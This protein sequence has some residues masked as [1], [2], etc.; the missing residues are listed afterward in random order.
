MYKSLL[1]FKHLKLI[2]LT[3]LIG[4][5]FSCSSSDSSD[6]FVEEISVTFS[7]SNT[8]VILGDSTILSWA[9]ETGASCVAGDG[10]TG[11]KQVSGNQTIYINNFGDNIFSLTCSNNS[12]AKKVSIVVKGTSPFEDE[13]ANIFGTTKYREV[14]NENTV[15]FPSFQFLIPIKLNADNIQDFIAHYWCDINQ[16]LW[17]TDH[18]QSTPDLIVAYLSHESGWYDGSFEIFGEEYPKLGGASRNYALGDINNDGKVDIAFAMN[19]EDGR[20]HS[21]WTTARTKPAAIISINGKYEII[22]IGEPEWGHSVEMVDN[23]FG[24]KD[25]LF[26]GFTG[27]GLQAFRWDIDKFINISSLYPPSNYFDGNGNM[28]ENGSNTWATEMK[29][30]G[31]LI[32][33]TDNLIDGS[34]KGFSIW[35][36]DSPNL[37]IKKDSFFK[38]RA[39]QVNWISWQEDLS[40]VDVFEID[41]RYIVDYTPQTM[42]FLNNYS[43]N[44]EGIYIVALY[45][46]GEYK[47]GEIDPENTYNQDDFDLL[48]FVKLYTFES[49]KIIEL[50][51]NIIGVNEYIF[52]NFVSCND[53]N[54]DG[55]SDLVRNVF[56]RDYGYK[57][58]WLR[59][60]APEV[61]INNKL[62]ELDNYELKTGFSFPGHKYEQN[63]MQGFMSDINND[64]ISDIVVFGQQASRGD[65]NIEIYFGKRNLNLPN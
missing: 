14:C 33:A 60:G 4:F 38:K 47:Y 5:L 24:F 39:F 19:Q 2:S 8:N 48:Q 44:D 20:S 57:T 37:W 49:N 65:G 41:G 43:G 29:A 62:N 16:E 64:G 50:D 58:P 55:F 54:N 61:Y 28:S 23:E 22:N 7:A 12:S 17:G 36:K 32:V 25:V 3:F 35:K 51:K 59:G 18:Y 53:I 21:D 26:A 34:E 11:N 27:I 15:N 42:C 6:E 1:I 9:S 46:G 52:A 10:W 40:Y 63:Y 31:N 45:S 30:S 13:P 56:S